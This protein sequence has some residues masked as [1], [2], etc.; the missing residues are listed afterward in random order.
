MPR[1]SPW[2]AL[3]GRETSSDWPSSW[4]RKPQHSSREL[5]SRCREGLRD[6]EQRGHH[7]WR[8][9][10]GEEQFYRRGTM[11]DDLEKTVK[12]LERR[13]TALEDEIAI[14]STLSTYGHTI[15]YGLE[16][17]WLDCSTED[18]VYRVQASGVTLPGL[19][20]ILQ[21]P[22]GLKGRAAT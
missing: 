17:Q 7:R 5:L 1:P 15:D 11:D 3:G 2:D 18:A 6:R 21:P 4:L 10:S 16:D 13:L 12:A 20:G 19:F 9:T 8:A 14:I 22:A